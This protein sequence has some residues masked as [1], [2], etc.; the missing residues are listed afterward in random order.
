MLSHPLV[1]E[2]AAVAVRRRPDIDESAGDEEVKVVV[3]L[4]DG[5]TLDPA[6]LVEYLPAA[7]R[8]TGC[9]GSSST[10]RRCRAPSR[11]SCKKGDL[12]DAG[13]TDATW[14]REAGRDPLLGGRSSA[15]PRARPIQDQLD[16]TT[17]EP[18]LVAGRCETCAECRFPLRPRC[19][20]A[21]ASRRADPAAP[22]RDALDLD[23]P[24][25]RAR[26]RRL[27]RRAAASS[28]RS[29]SDT[30]SSRGSARRGT[31]HRGRPG[32]PADRA[33]DGGRRDRAR[34]RQSRT[35]SRRTRS[36][37]SD[38]RSPIIGAGIHPFGRHEGMSG[39]AMGVHAV[40]AALADA[41]LAWAEMQFAY[42]GS[43]D[44]GN[45]DTMV[46]DLGPTGLPFVNVQNGCA[47]G[48]SSLVSAVRAHPVGR[49]RRRPGRRLRQA[50]ARRV[51]QTSRG[52]VA[53]RL[54]RARSA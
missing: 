28:C 21:A 1:K 8:V 24:G 39:L 16:V 48:G 3:V 33:G 54:V 53:A 42:G 46:A 37:D 19:R 38:A 34:R 4:E 51:R 12:R 44:A 13:V 40:R 26:V 32:A 20:R 15:E 43:E 41:G 49:V 18:R 36:P 17:G 23:D 30:S 22:T 25:L 9:R 6:E 27:R 5:A 10:P 45:A 47:T 11:T 2:A 14:D 50:S 7:C 31:A 29:P 52:L 35:R